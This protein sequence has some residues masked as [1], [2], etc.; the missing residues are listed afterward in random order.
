MLLCKWIKGF[1]NG[2]TFTFNTNGTRRSQKRQAPQPPV[3]SH[4]L[5]TPVTDDSDSESEDEDNEVTT[6][7]DVVHRDEVIG[8]SIKN[9]QIKHEKNE[10]TN[11]DVV[12]KNEVTINVVPD[13]PDYS[14]NTEL[15]LDASKLEVNNDSLKEVNDDSLKDET[16][17]FDQAMATMTMKEE[18]KSDQNGNIVEKEHDMVDTVKDQDSITVKTISHEKSGRKLDIAGWSSFVE[19]IDNNVAVMFQMFH[20]KR[21]VVTINLVCCQLVKTALIYCR[22]LLHFLTA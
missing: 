18:K 15:V 6:N 1:N 4:S 7:K 17:E 3:R 12:Y 14:T 20:V 19:G 2:T 21:V 5:K 13:E 11:K 22:Y 10:V 16:D 8:V 9:D